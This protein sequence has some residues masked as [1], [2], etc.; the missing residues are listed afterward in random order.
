M[1]E[2]YKCVGS[3][4]TIEIILFEQNSEQL[5]SLYKEGEI[6]RNVMK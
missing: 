1:M 4:S 5:K 3:N 2:L 6:K